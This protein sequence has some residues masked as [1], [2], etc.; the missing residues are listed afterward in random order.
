M[1]NKDTGNF[2]SPDIRKILIYD[3]KII[4]K[5]SNKNLLQIFEAM[6]IK[7]KKRNYE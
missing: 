3:T 6:T 7:N 4:Y 1:N 2:T 5:S